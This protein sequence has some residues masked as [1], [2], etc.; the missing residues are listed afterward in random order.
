MFINDSLY[1]N[2]CYK[3]CENYYYFNESNDY[4]CTENCSGIYNKLIPEKNKCINKCE[5]DDI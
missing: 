3:K 5:N 1:K 2:N 4:I